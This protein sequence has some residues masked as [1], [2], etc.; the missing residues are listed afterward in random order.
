MIYEKYDIY[1]TESIEDY[2]SGNPYPGRGIIIGLNPD[3]KKAV[4]AYF[5][6]GRSANSRNRVFEEVDDDLMIKPFDESKVEDPSLII[7]YPVRVYDKK[8]IITNGD[9]TDT[10]HKFLKEG[11]SFQQALATRSF[12]PDS[13]NWTPR[14]SGIVD[15]ERGVRYC[16]SI[17]KSADLSYHTVCKLRQSGISS[18][19]LCQVPV[20]VTNLIRRT[21][22]S[23][24]NKIMQIGV[25]L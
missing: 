18:D 19:R 13:P 20:P 11:K 23:D 16:M 5:I 7:Y 24:I 21:N 3:G 8:I 25:K 6:T 2:I 1:R 14:I 4:F 9:Q 22:A 17:L 12:E 15:I 10:V